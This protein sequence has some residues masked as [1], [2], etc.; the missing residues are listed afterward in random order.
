MARSKEEYENIYA[1]LT[2]YDYPAGFFKNDKRALHRKA[3]DNYK[4]ES[5]A[6]FYRQRQSDDWKQVPR[7]A[8]ERQR[9]LE[10]CHSLPEG[11]LRQSIMFGV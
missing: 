2:R 6:L 7:N 3:S 1:F 5:C 4:V 9:I 8:H 10:T 11:M